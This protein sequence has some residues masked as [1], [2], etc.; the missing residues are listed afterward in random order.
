MLSGSLNS[1]FL[2][3]AS[4]ES[5]LSLSS[6]RM[7]RRP[8]QLSESAHTA[9]HCSPP[10]QTSQ[11]L[12]LAAAHLGSHVQPG[13]HQAVGVC[14]GWG[15]DTFPIRF[16]SELRDIHLYQKKTAHCN[17]PN[18]QPAPNVPSEGFCPAGMHRTSQDS[19][20]YHPRATWAL[21]EE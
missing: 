8:L 15:M 11:T 16:G 20:E 7:A 4:L 19:A 13:A 14:G 3:L 9:G 2:V 12:G 5:S 6:D 21:D 1:A 17:S 18:P 10:T